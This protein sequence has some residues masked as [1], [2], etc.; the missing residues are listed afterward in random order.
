MRK[1]AR[2]N[3]VSVKIKT[4]AD[5]T[6]NGNLDTNMY[7]FTLKIESFGRLKGIANLL[8]CHTLRKFMVLKFT[9]VSKYKR[10]GRR[11]GRGRVHV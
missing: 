6:E 4:S 2:R 3:H 11:R 5:L 1:L 7:T 10:K 8:N 9:H